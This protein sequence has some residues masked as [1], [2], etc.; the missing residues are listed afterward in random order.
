[1]SSPDRFRVSRARLAYI[2]ERYAIVDELMTVPEAIAE[3]RLTRE[4]LALLVLQGRLAVAEAVKQHPDD[5]PPRLLLRAEIAALE[6]RVKQEPL[7]F[8][9]PFGDRGRAGKPSA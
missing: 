4:T 9:G 8:A 6:A 5:R 1:M 7:P 2:F 3:A